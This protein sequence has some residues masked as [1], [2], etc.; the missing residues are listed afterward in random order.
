[1]TERIFT[2]T[3]KLS[4]GC[5]QIP[6]A[7]LLKSPIWKQPR[8]R[9]SRTFTL[10]KGVRSLTRPRSITVWLTGRGN[11]NPVAVFEPNLVS[12]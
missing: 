8:R 10:E 12:P 11:G 7:N 1:M 4:Q 2:I 5:S 6:W 9:G 3:P